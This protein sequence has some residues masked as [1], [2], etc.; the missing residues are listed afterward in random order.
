MC[1]VELRC[2]SV[3]GGGDGGRT[4]LSASSAAVEVK[5]FCDLF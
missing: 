1:G 4:L 5:G 2:D 3:G